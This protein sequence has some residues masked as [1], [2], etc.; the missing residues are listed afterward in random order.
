MLDCPSF[1]KP[2]QKFYTE[3]AIKAVLPECT[4]YEYLC[5][6]SRGVLDDVAI[7][8]IAIKYIASKITYRELL[9]NIDKTAEAFSSMG[10]RKGDIVTLALPNI[11]ENIYAVYALN[12]I[13]AIAN[14]I[15]LRTKGKDLLHYYSEVDAQ[16]VVAC[17]LFLKNTLDIVD[18][19]NI[20]KIIVASPFD[21]LPALIRCA[22]KLKAKTKKL[23]PGELLITWK[24]FVKM[25]GDAK[26]MPHKGS[27][28]DPVCIL[29]TSGTTGTPKGVML[30]NR[31]FNSMVVQYRH[32]GLDFNPNETFFNEVPPFLAYN[33]VMAV[34]LPLC[35][36]LQ[37]ILMPDY[38]PDKFVQNMI[39]YKPNHVIAGP[40][41]W[42]NFMDDPDA[43]RHDFSF[44]KTMASGGDAMVD[45]NKQAVN[46]MLEK[47]GCKH[48]IIEGY[49]MTE[50]ASAACTNLPQ[51]DVPNSVGIPLPLTS[52]CIY[53][54]DTNSEL[55]CNTTGEICMTGPT[56]MLGYYG[57]E[58]ETNAI[59]Q[60]HSDGKL[61]IHSGDLGYISD[62]GVVFVV[63]RLK[64]IFVRHDG[65]KLYPFKMEQ[66]ILKDERIAECCVVGSPDVQ[67]GHGQIP[68]AFIS[69]KQD[70]KDTPEVIRTEVEAYCRSQTN[71]GYSPAEYNVIDRLPRTPNGK[72][73]Y[74]ALEKVA[75]NY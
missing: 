23:K 18:Q 9:K 15:D 47:Q 16:I 4:M 50:I 38:H 14:L 60:R 35:L 13:G 39:K 53:D 46:R 28:H 59:M 22:A 31:S 32:C 66:L 48:K 19:T 30:P 42:N 70:A 2:W 68:I 44:L 24:D 54:N 72:V 34:H 7:K 52:F 51:C 3:E 61:W 67:H 40:A 57:K 10:V 27:I 36:H 41:N 21:S 25:K 5:E 12:K 49:G 64:R 55:P 11:P 26:V 33:V 37:V 65:I 8:Y 75:D 62:D 29:H 56:L 6:C 73:D 58:N 71:D 45:K 20:K 69:I 1:D 74:R 17:D 43:Y 63:G